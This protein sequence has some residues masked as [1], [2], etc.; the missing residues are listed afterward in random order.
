VESARLSETGQTQS[1]IGRED[2]GIVLTSTPRIS[3]DGYV[4]IELKQE[5]SSFSGENVQLTEG[6]SSPIF[7][8]REVDTNVTVRDGETVI[9]GGLITSRQSEAENKVPLL[10]D[11]PLVGPL[12][13]ASSVNEQ[14]TELLVVLTVDI[15]R[16]DEDRYQMSVE[17]RDNF[18]LP[19]SI[20]QN[21]LMEGLRILP[22]ESGLGPVDEKAKKPGE[23]AAPRAEPAPERRE[24]YGPKPKVYGPVI[25]QPATTSTALEP[26]Y[27]PQIAQ[28]EP[29]EKG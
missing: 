1:T 2:V 7:S 10:G 8:T 13:R 23:V 9:I 29:S 15:L 14:K 22:E 19:D 5:L 3:P 28:N 25:R 26:V 27:G 21:P 4:T 6:V 20:R 24:L 16:T 12:F 11:L 17:Q 18:V